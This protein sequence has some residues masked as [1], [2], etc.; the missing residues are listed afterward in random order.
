MRAYISAAAALSASVHTMPAAGRIAALRLSTMRPRASAVTANA[1]EPTLLAAPKFMWQQRSSRSRLSWLMSGPVRLQHAMQRQ[2]AA[3]V[4]NERP[5]TVISTANS[6]ICTAAVAHRQW[7]IVMRREEST[8]AATAGA[9]R[10]PA[11]LPSA[12]TA[13][14]AVLEYPLYCMYT[15]AK[16]THMQ[17]PIQY[18][19]CTAA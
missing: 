9:S 11:M 12:T 19:P 3:A 13:P 2:Y 14:S 15:A 1:K 7:N 10:K 6:M 18:I 5:G 8:S 16:A 4:A 17:K